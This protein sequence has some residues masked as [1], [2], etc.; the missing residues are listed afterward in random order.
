MHR[1]ML[2][3][4]LIMLGCGEV[5]LAEVDAMTCP[6]DPAPV[7]CEQCERLCPETGWGIAYAELFQVVG[8]NAWEYGGFMIFVNTGADALWVT[9]PTITQLRSWGSGL[10]LLVQA[11]TEPVASWVQPGTGYGAVDFEV[12]NVLA[13][14]PSIS[15][16]SVADS[17]PLLTWKSSSSDRL[18]AATKQIG[19]EFDGLPGRAVLPLTVYTN[20]YGGNDGNGYIRA[21]S[22]RFICAEASE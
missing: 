14:A 2:A 15:E 21:N 12:A 6:V 4:G 10:Q 16:L 9:T 18:A 1:I 19:L 17:T 22:A 8:A 13:E 5:T 3:A 20:S 7:Q 11:G